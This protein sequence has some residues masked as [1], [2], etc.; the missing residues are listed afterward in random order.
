[1]YVL[2]IFLLFSQ[3]TGVIVVDNV[4]F[5][6]DDQKMI[7]LGTGTVVEIIEYEDDLVKVSYEERIG[8]VH[9]G[10]LIDFESPI[11]EKK[12]FVFARGYFDDGAYSQAASLFEIFIRSFQE[13][14]YLCEALYYYGLSNEWVAKVLTPADSLPGFVFNENYN[15]WHYSG[16]SYERIRDEFPGSVYAS[17]AVYRLLSVIRERNLP[18]RD[19]LQ[20]IQEELKMWQDFI[21]KYRDTEEYVLAL[22]E[23]G[24][25]NRVLFEITANADFEKNAIDVF[26]EISDTYP[27]SVF[28]AQSDLN[29]YE[30]DHGENI[31]KY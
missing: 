13:S 29:L 16:E 14:Q 9:R 24:Y 30:I 31:Y 20:P 19:S 6:G 11:A 26:Q 3:G 1:M 17:K 25:L 8:K 23:I 27:K 28:S 21:V 15:T 4:W 22:L 5:Y 10:V 7:S 2:L 12:L 18:W